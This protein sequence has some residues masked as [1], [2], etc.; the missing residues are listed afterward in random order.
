[1]GGALSD[2]WVSM[3]KA[4]LAPFW[5]LRSH[6]I[7]R[8]PGGHAEWRGASQMLPPEINP[9]V[10][11]P[12]GFRPGETLFP[13]KNPSDH[14]TSSRSSCTASPGNSSGTSCWSG[15]TSVTLPYPSAEGERWA[16]VARVQALITQYSGTP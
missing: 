12:R 5:L 14:Q 3:A 6:S 16:F 4:L 1:M 7:R 13:P 10:L 9:Q 11:H 15:V 2:K 8:V